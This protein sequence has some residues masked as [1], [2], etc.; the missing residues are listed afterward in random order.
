M[1]T[2]I[3]RGG[4]LSQKYQVALV[5]LLS[6]PRYRRMERS[7]CCAIRLP[8]YQTV[9]SIILTVIILYLKATAAY[10]K[11]LAT[12]LTLYSLPDA[13]SITL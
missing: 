13:Y 4:E 6:L 8:L 12:L 7:Q 10:S 11:E 5:G 3:Q 1:Q 2:S 9:Y